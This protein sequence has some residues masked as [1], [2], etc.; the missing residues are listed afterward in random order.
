MTAGLKSSPV[1]PGEVERDDIVRG[2]TCPVCHVGVGEP[3][4]Y[5]QTVLG[6]HMRQATSHAGRYR[7]A[8]EAGAVPVLFGMLLCANP[9][10]R[11][12]YELIK[13]NKRTCS[14]S[15]ADAVARARRE[16]GTDAIVEP[17]WTS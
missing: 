13:H 7:V 15:C 6:N 17:T 9:R 4:T 1:Q 16:Y 10:C 12:P 5:G 8:C 3:C 14:K 11:L 2:Y